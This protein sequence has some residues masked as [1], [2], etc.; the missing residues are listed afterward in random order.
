MPEFQP[1]LIKWDADSFGGEEGDQTVGPLEPLFLA[2][3]IKN[4][5]ITLQNGLEY[6]Q[7]L[8]WRAGFQIKL[9]CQIEFLQKHGKMS[10]QKVSILAARDVLQRPDHPY[11]SDMSVHFVR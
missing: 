9:F 10:C 8:Y 6:L 7:C 5:W 2:F 3:W 11:I 4:P 1:T